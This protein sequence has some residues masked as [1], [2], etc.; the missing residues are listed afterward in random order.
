MLNKRGRE[1]VKIEVGEA[2]FASLTTVILDIN[3]KTFA[4]F[5]TPGA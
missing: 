5:G 4:R 1:A 2:N 3:K